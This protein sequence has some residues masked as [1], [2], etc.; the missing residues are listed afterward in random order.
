MRFNI[1]TYALSFALTLGLT[2]APNAQGKTF[3]IDTQKSQIKWTGKKITEKHYG[4]IKVKTGDVIIDESGLTGGKIVIDMTSITCDDIKRPKSNKKFIK[5]LK[6][7]DFFK[8]DKFPE[9][10]L[11]IKTATKSSEGKYNISADMTILD[12]TH[13]IQFTLSVTPNGN[14]YQAKGMVVIDRTKWG[15]RYGSGTFFDNLGNRAILDDF[16]I[17][18]ELH[19]R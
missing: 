15:I 9:S 3:S 2:F 16:D 10:S 18:F 13:P 6:N 1:L 17:E 11:N 4:K 12:Q 7:D 8:T 5:H 19:T 14:G